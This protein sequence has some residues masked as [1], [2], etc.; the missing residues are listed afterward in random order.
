MDILIATDMQHEALVRSIRAG[1]MTTLSMGCTIDFS[2]C[3]K[4]GHVAPDESSMCPHIKYMKGNTFYDEQGNQNII[5][6]ICGHSSVDPTGGVQ[7]IEASWVG[8]PAFTGAVLRNVLEP[9]EAQVQKAARILSMPPKQW[10]DDSMLKAASLV[11]TKSGLLIPRSFT[12]VGKL[13]VENDTFVKGAQDFP[14]QT[15]MSSAVLRNLKASEMF[16]AG[17]SDDAMDDNSGGDDP[18]DT[19]PAPDA[20]KEEKSPVDDMVKRLEDYATKEVE[21]RIKD[22]IQ[23]KDTPAIPPKAN[24]STNETLVK[25]ASETPWGNLS[26]LVRTAS[27]DVALVDSLAA[28]NKQAGI[29]IPVALYRASLKVGST[30]TYT[31]VEAFKSACDKALGRR[32]S[33]SEV[34]I[35]VRIGKLLSRRGSSVQAPVSGSR[36]GGIQ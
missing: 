7:F 2:T 20:P 17:W 24:S 6:E 8:T 18:G 33:L 16:L 34:K 29:S 19:A 11:E 35:L 13:A 15:G 32:A 12:P 28:Q 4:C 23:K 21:R 5:C 25:Q 3:S 30:S 27:S 1:E 31:T 36:H 14:G 22:R 10:S 9:T 26:V